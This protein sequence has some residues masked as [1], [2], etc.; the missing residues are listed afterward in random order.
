MDHGIQVAHALAKRSP[1]YEQKA[2]TSDLDKNWFN[3]FLPY[4]SIRDGLST[5]F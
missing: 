4:V 5:T 1:S 2:L 3:I